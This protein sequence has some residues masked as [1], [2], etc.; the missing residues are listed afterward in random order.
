MDQFGERRPDIAIARRAHLQ[1][2]VHIVERDREAFVEPADLLEDLLADDK[3]RR[4]DRADVLHG[5][6]PVQVS[7]VIAARE[8]MSMPGE[9]IEAEHDTAMLDAPSG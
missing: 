4:R 9:A 3:A 2:E 1:A 7:G 5:A 6:Q 8:A